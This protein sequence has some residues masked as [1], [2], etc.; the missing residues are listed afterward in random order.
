[1]QLKKKAE[2]SHANFFSFLLFVIILVI[3]VFIF[4]KP[5]GHFISGIVSPPDSIPL[6]TRPAIP[7]PG[8]TGAVRKATVAPA[9]EKRITG[10]NA[11]MVVTGMID[12][13]AREPG[14][15]TTVVAVEK[16]IVTGKVSVITET[17]ETVTAA[18]LS[19]AVTRTASTRVLTGQAAYV[20]Y[21]VKKGD[22]LWR[23]AVT[24]GMTV[25]EL[26]STN[27][28]STNVVLRIGDTLTVRNV[29]TTAPVPKKQEVPEPETGATNIPAVKTRNYTVK[30]NDT[31]FSLARIYGCTVTELQAMNNNA[32]LQVNQVIRVP[33]LEVTN[34]HAQT[35]R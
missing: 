29:T 19:T 9:A 31:Y 27:N 7:V 14:G 11:G 5:L 33:D 16:P 12:T 3:L 21:T 6:D 20:S 1:L 28:V 26:C 35:V 24:H 25:N 32:A 2:K 34:A 4:R 23:I 13:T 15:T 30:K 8:E 10:V 17:V 18:V 22:S